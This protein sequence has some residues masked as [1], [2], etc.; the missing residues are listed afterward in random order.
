[1]DDKRKQDKEPV[2]K[3]MAK[4][5]PPGSKEAVTVGCKCPV[6]DNH[7]GR[8]IPGRDGEHHYFMSESCP[9]HGMAAK[10]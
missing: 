10:G 5:Y 3:E 8:G 6:L 1:M 2:Q 4:R 9:L 7:R